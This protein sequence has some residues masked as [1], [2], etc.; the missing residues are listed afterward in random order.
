VRVAAEIDQLGQR[1]AAGDHAAAANSRLSL[2]TASY[3]FRAAG[4]LIA[5]IRG[6]GDYMDWYCSGPYATVTY[7]T[8]AESGEP[9]SLGDAYALGQLNAGEL[10]LV[11]LGSRPAEAPAHY[12]S[13]GRELSVARDRSLN[14]LQPSTHPLGGPHVK[15]GALLSSD[16]SFP[17][18]IP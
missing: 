18:L 2:C 13:L 7:G 4:D 1:R 15:G 6:R 9:G 8:G 12:A 3:S 16:W 11:G 5:A 14:G 17:L 10:D